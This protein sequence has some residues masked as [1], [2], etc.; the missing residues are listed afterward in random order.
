MYFHFY[1]SGKLS[2]LVAFWLCLLECLGAFGQAVLIFLHWSLL[3][4]QVYKLCQETASWLA[5]LINYYSSGQ[6]EEKTQHWLLLSIPP[7]LRNMC[8]LDREGRKYFG[9]GEVKIYSEINILF[10]KLSLHYLTRGFWTLQLD[11]ALKVWG[12]GDVKGENQLAVALSF[13]SVYEHF[14]WQITFL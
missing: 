9:G 12:K 1:S 3:R 14:F 6:T 10:K 11:S 5:Q 4:Y 2:F 13:S 8:R 7:C